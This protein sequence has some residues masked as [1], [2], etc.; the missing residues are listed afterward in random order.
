MSTKK[1]EGCGKCQSGEGNQEHPDEKG[2]GCSKDTPQEE[3]PVGQNHNWTVV[4]LD[5]AENSVLMDG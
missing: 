5:P 2:C 3:K 1:C 4:A